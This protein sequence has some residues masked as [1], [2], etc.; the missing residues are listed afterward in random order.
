MPTS[1]NDKPINL[2]IDTRI[3]GM[4]GAVGPNG[5]I[6][7]HPLN[8]DCVMLAKVI[9]Y[10]KVTSQLKWRS[11]WAPDAPENLAYVY[12][13][14]RTEAAGDRCKFLENDMTLVY[15]TPKPG[16]V[17]GVESVTFSDWIC[18]TGGA[19]DAECAPGVTLY[20]SKIV[21]TDNCDRP[22]EHPRVEIDSEKI[23][24]QLPSLVGTLS[25]KD[26]LT[27]KVQ[28]LNLCNFETG[29]ATVQV[30]VLVKQ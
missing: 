16:Q 2:G 5:E 4:Y 22:D 26:V 17:A 6:I 14:H 10:D 20:A 11:A 25:F 1:P 15:R 12:M 9:H 8:T 23:L 21:L 3:K 27:A 19:G 18:F 7:S 30:P 28:M 24:Y 13:S 29:G